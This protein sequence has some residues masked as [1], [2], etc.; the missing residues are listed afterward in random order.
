MT[1]SEEVGP[2]KTSSTFKQNSH[3]KRSW[4]L[5][6]GLLLFSCCIGE[7]NS[8]QSLSALS[9]STHMDCSIFRPSVHHNSQIATSY[10]IECMMPS[11]TSLILYRPLLLPASNASMGTFQIWPTLPSLAKVLEFPSFSISSSNGVQLVPLGLTSWISIESKRV[12]QS[13]LYHSSK[14]INS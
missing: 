6:G 13:L 9:D 10:C 11:N 12:L 2:G 7:F 3:Q 14:S 8:V 1:S 4:S 5:F